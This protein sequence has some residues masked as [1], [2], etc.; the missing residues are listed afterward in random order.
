MLPEFRS[1]DPTSRNSG[2][3][4]IYVDYLY[5]DSSKRDL[6]NSESWRTQGD[7]GTLI[8]LNPT[9]ATGG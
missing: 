9:S 4:T 6:D 1:V 7:V 2:D 3:N 8:A 5:I